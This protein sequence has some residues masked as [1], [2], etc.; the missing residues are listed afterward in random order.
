MNSKERLQRWECR[1]DVRHRSIWVY[2]E[3]WGKDPNA[4]PFILNQLG[5]VI[6]WNCKWCGKHMRVLRN[7]FYHDKRAK[8]I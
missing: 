8:N 3:N 2:Y 5:Y 7:Y 4:D 6:H 1:T